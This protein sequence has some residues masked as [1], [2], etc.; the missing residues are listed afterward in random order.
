MRP[1][2]RCLCEKRTAKLFRGFSSYC[3]RECGNL[4]YESQLIR[5]LQTFRHLHACPGCFRL[6]R[7]PGGT[8][9]HWK[10]P[11]F[12][13]AHPMRTWGVAENPNG[14]STGGF[15]AMAGNVTCGFFA[16]PHYFLKPDT[17]RVSLSARHRE[18]T[19]EVCARKGDSDGTAGC[20]GRRAHSS[21]SNSRPSLC[22]DLISDKD[23]HTAHWIFE[24]LRMSKGLLVA[25]RS[26]ASM[27]RRRYFGGGR[28]SCH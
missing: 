20:S 21:D 17:L 11:P 13:G 8:C 18:M 9:T 22:S 26:C 23:R 24:R 14:A 16:A 10:A 28:C 2:F 15:P 4:A 27:S 19:L 5:R 7:S 12:H 25:T 1:W 6:E 3:C